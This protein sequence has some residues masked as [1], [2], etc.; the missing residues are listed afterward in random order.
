MSKRIS[1]EELK[2]CGFV[3]EVF[4]VEKGD[5]EKF[6][7]LVLKEVD[8]RLGDHLVGDSLLEIKKLI[9]RPE[10]DVMDVQNV[11]ETFAGLERFMTGVPQEEFRKV[12]S[13]QKRH[14]L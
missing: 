11:R 7:E 10:M 14:K 8:D 2:A 9:R 13:G 1:A 6:K 5:S 4:E 12:S 3:N